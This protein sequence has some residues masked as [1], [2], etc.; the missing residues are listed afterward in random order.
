VVG[1]DD[2]TVHENDSI[3]LVLDEASEKN[4]VSFGLFARATNFTKIRRASLT[5]LALCP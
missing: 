3:K 2:G 5:N 4:C 1:E